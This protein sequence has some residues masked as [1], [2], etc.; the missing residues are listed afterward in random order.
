MIAGGLLLAR[1]ALLPNT[2]VIPTL[3]VSN[4]SVL[5]GDSGTTDAVFN[6]TLDKAYDIPIALGFG[7]VPEGEFLHGAPW[8]GNVIG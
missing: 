2:T 5:E 8:N 6:V 4:V 3:T 1:R 7:P